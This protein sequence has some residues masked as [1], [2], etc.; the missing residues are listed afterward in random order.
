MYPTIIIGTVR[1]SWTWLW[2]RYH[3]PKKVFLVWR[4]V[5]LF[6]LC[7]WVQACFNFQ[8]RGQMP[9]S[10]DASMTIKPLRVRVY[11]SYWRTVLTAAN[12]EMSQT[13]SAFLTT[14]GRCVLCERHA[15]RSSVID[16]E[17]TPSEAAEI[18]T[19]TCFVSS[20]P[21]FSRPHHF[22]IIIISSSSSSRPNIKQEAHGL[23]QSAGIWGISGEL[24]LR[25]KCSGRVS[26]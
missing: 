25:E 21:S 3:V 24:I 5:C 19:I 8:R 10:G 9:L 23:W 11:L 20:H 15:Q 16:D 7:S 17:K 14:G 6:L 1:S 26:E 2:G 22:I 12:R 18:I 4:W 13:K